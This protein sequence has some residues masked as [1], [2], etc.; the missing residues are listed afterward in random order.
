[1]WAALYACYVTYSLFHSF[2]H[3]NRVVWFVGLLWSFVYRWPLSVQSL[4]L[5]R[6]T[7]DQ[8][9]FVA[10]VA[11][12]KQVEII[13]ESKFGE[14][15]IQSIVTPVNYIFSFLF[16]YPTVPL[17]YD[18]AYCEV[19]VD[20]VTGTSR[21]FHRMCRYIYNQEAAMYV[22]GNMNVGTT[23]EDFLQQSDG[24]TSEEATQRLHTV[25]RNMIPMTKPTIL[26]NIFR[27]FSK[28]FY[29][30]QNFMVWTWAPYH[31]YY[32]AITQ[33][34]VRITGGVVVGVFQYMSDSVLYQI[35]HVE[36]TVR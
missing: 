34:I 2:F 18:I 6:C 14:N 16:S 4:F 7:L 24:L 11:R 29:L 35:S 21:F 32:M 3:N 13:D 27:E 15:L 28:I 10:V 19:A 17:G 36:G 1:M 23:M 33:S 30:Y 20:R 31:Y 8:S 9:S 12:Q 26:G 5:R 22:I 25:G